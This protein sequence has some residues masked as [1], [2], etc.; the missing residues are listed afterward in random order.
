VT[1]AGSP[2]RVF[3][4]RYSPLVQI[5]SL[6]LPVAFFGALAAAATSSTAMSPGL[7]SL[8]LALGIGTSLVPFLRIR[9]IVFARQLVIRRHFL[10]ETS[11]AHREIAEVGKDAIVGGGLRIRLGGLR[12]SDRLR[13]AV[14]QWIAAQVLKEAAA[15]VEKQPWIYPTRGYGGYAGFWGIIFGMISLFLRPSWF[16]LDARWVMAGVFLIVYVLYIYVLPRSLA[17]SIDKPSGRA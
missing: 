3:T 6:G 12:N 8:T 9:D 7:W 5:A 16:P 1:V 2:V 15:R 4:P 11:L 13:E 10:P 14:R 17:T